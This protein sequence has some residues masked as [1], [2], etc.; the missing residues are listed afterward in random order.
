MSLLSQILGHYDDKGVTEVIVRFLLR[1]S[2]LESESNQIC[3]L[4]L[5]EFLA[6]AILSQLVGFPKLR[7]F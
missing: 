7:Y 6:N 5:D 2:S 3:C 1:I 4:G